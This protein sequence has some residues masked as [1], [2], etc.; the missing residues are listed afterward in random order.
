M[1]LEKNSRFW[2]IVL[3]A[4]GA[5]FLFSNLG[6]L[7]WLT[8]LVWGLLFLAGGVA[9]LA[10]FYANRSKWWALIPGF[11]LIGLSTVVFFGD[12]AVS[13]LFI[14]MGLSFAAIYLNDEQHWWALIPAGTILTLA[15]IIWAEQVFPR[16]NAGSLLFLGLAATFGL[17]YLLPK[18]RGGQLWA[19]FPAVGCLALVLVISGFS[20]GLWG[21]LLSLLLIVGGVYLLWRQR[22]QSSPSNI[23][24]VKKPN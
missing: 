7:P 20:G 16:W 17:L 5:L 21:V 2:A 14:L 12:A 23:D 10:V 8:S 24:S 6:W 3:V 15:L 13:W 22:G 4:L 1:T 18:N 19:I 11:S 9:F